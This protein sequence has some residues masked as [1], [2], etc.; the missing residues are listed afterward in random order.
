MSEQCSRE[1]K[2]RSRPA[3]TSSATRTFFSS[4]RSKSLTIR[5]SKPVGAKFVT[6]L[7]KSSVAIVKVQEWCPV[8]ANSMNFNFIHP[9]KGDLNFLSFLDVRVVIEFK[10]LV[11]VFAVLNTGFAVSFNLEKYL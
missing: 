1:E 10:R 2:R 9:W 4:S 7:A 6:V 11:F 5:V 8:N 3:G